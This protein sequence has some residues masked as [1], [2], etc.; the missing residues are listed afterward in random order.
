MLPVVAGV[1]ETKRHILLYTLL[2]APLGVVPAMIGMASWY[3]GAV[4][5]ALGI[6]FVAMAIGIMRDTGET[7]ARRT[8][9]FSL[10][11]LSALFAALIVDRALG[12][13]G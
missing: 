11:Y 8:F 2:L 12:L 5:A 10:L 1:A 7:F 4:A 3:F 13:A 6:V 9:L